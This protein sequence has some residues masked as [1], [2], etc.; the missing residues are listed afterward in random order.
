RFE[1]SRWLLRCCKNR[2]PSRALLLVCVPRR[3][4]AT[5]G[6]PFVCYWRQLRIHKRRQNHRI[7]AFQPVQRMKPL[8]RA[9][10]IVPLLRT[11]HVRGIPVLLQKREISLFR[12][13]LFHAREGGGEP[14]N[15]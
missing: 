11:R 14:P 13:K 10:P 2:R 1:G 9:S 7:L 5:T 15:K 12:T 3:A 4:Q 6:L 8:S